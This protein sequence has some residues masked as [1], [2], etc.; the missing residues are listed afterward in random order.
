[1]IKKIFVGLLIL[2]ILIVGTLIAVPYIFKDD[3]VKLV[4]T[5]ANKTVN[6]KI[7]FGHFDLSLIKS[8][9]DFYFSIEGIKVD[10]IG[11]FDG[12]QLA[13][14]K[15]IDLVVDLMSVINGEAINIKRIT[16]LEPTINTIVMADGSANYDI[17]KTD[18]TDV[19]ETEESDSGS[20]FK[21][22]LQQFDI[23]DAMLK[24]D[25][26]TFPMLMDIEGLN[27]S[28]KGDFTESITNLKIEGGA[29]QLTLDYDGIHYMKQVKIFLDM[30][31][32]MNLDESKYTFIENE[33]RIN[34]LPLSFDGWV[35]MPSDAIDMDLS[36][37]AKKTDFKEILSLVPAEFTHDLEGVK[38][39][40][41][42][43]LSGYAK[44]IYLDEDYPSFGAK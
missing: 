38:T 6:A 16:I 9:P 4:K 1:M 34:E 41:K 19:E 20:S 44:G 7:D 32:E 14:I 30:M 11:E 17:A 33:F 22:E 31:L 37:E 8:F 21:M 27:I 25:D 35:A 13:N 42:M 40:G 24:Y 12:V 10:G 23:V 5:E 36:F 3:I 43:A 18:S 28:L 15:E 2:V 39:S 26:A 29:D